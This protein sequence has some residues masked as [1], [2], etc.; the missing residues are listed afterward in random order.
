VTRPRAAVVGSGV[1]GLTAAYLLQRRYDV[2]LFESDGRLGGH[3][4]THDVERPGGGVVPIDT[5]FIVHNERTY[6]QLLRLFDTLGVR[7]QDS[8]MS[9]SVRCDGCGLEYAGARGPRGLFAD[10]RNLARPQ[11]LRMLVEV[12]RFHRDARRLLNADDADAELVT[13]GRFLSDGGYTRYFVDHFMMP[14]VSAVWST[15]PGT[16]A[17]Q[18][19]RNLFRFLDNHGMLAVGGSP[20]WRTVVGG[21]REYVDKVADR[22]STVRVATP[23]RTVSHGFGA[24]EVRDH[25][26]VVHE[27]DRAVIATHPDDALAILT[28]P[29]VTQKEILGAFTYSPNEAWLHTDDSVLPRR[30]A[31]RASWNYWKATCSSQETRPLMSYHLN[32]LMR[33]D[34]PL[35]Y[36]VTL[37]GSGRVADSSVI[38]QMSYAHPIFT[39]ESVAAQRRLPEINDGT[40]AFAGAYHG[41]GF[42]EDGCA[43]GV[44]AAASLGASW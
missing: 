28:D 3:A 31:A 35:S 8:E 21:S 43:A 20:R 23:V 24:V 22:L 13:L 44:R 5:G 26:D 14:L 42:H 4:H 34:E 38:E 19:A 36:L 12:K 1:A 29:S 10:P 37:N 6:P 41:W 15:G 2:T 25:A 39:P 9:M 32:R 16:S 30:T 17:E 18:P 27:F 11:F 7:T 33:L 40:V